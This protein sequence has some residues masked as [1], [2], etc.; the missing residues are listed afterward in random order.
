MA[1]RPLAVHPYCIWDGLRGLWARTRTTRLQEVGPVN[2]WF[3]VGSAAVAAAV[4][5]ALLAGKDDIR[6][7]RQIRNM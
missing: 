5:V 1:R 6:R 4:C 7:F 3:V 2:T